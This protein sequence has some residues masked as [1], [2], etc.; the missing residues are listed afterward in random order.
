MEETL[1]IYFQI[2]GKWNC[3]IYRKYIYLFFSLRR[4][5]TYLIEEDWIKEKNIDMDIVLPYKNIESL[6]EEN[7]KDDNGLIGPDNKKL[8]WNDPGL[9]DLLKKNLDKGDFA[10]K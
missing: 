8:K 2:D 6:E 1:N 5:D 7:L 9:L 4:I 10:N 3:N